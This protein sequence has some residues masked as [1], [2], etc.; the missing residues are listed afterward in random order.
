MLSAKKGDQESITITV[1]QEANQA[2]G[3]TQIHIQHTTV[4]K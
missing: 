3:K 1:S 2:G 4:T